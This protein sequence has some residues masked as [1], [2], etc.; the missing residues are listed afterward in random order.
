MFGNG[1]S[2]IVWQESIATG[3]RSRLLS[4]STLSGS[5]LISSGSSLISDVVSTFSGSIF[6]SAVESDLLV[7]LLTIGWVIARLEVLS[8]S[9]SNGDPGAPPSS[10]VHGLGILGVE[11][12]FPMA[13]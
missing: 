9:I 3:F 13:I 4:V 7:V 6:T 10:R 2:L 8:L 1:A 5:I 12:D 11:V